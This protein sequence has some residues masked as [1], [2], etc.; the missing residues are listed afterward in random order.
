MDERKQEIEKELL[1]E[2]NRIQIEGDSERIPNEE[3]EMSE[4]D[5]IDDLSIEND[6]YDEEE[7]EDNMELTASEEDYMIES[8]MERMREKKEED[9]G[10]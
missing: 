6:G 10:Y 5:E 2:Y 7:T 1:D 8:G 9:E 4:L 3:D